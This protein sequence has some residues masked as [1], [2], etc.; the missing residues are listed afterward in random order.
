MARILVIDDSAS[1]LELASRLLRAAGHAVLTSQD[2]E[3]AIALA[4]REHPDLIMS[5]IGLPGMGGLEIAQRIRRTPSLAGIPLV[6]F[7]GH[8]DP[9]DRSTIL[10]AGFDGYVPKAYSPGDLA[11]IEAFLP[12]A[13]R[14]PAARR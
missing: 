2:G 10:A 7:T 3:G 13:L 4:Q 1:D 5:D 12:E 14:S 9:G 8:R 6:A 11:A